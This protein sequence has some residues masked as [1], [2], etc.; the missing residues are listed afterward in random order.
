MYRIASN[1]SSANKPSPHLSHQQRGQV[2]RTMNN[3]AKE[4]HGTLRDFTT[5]DHVNH[6]ISCS[7]QY[8]WP[9]SRPWP[10]WVILYPDRANNGP[11]RPSLAALRNLDGP[12]LLVRALGSDVRTRSDMLGPLFFFVSRLGGR[13]RASISTFGVWLSL[14]GHRTP[15]DAT[16]ARCAQEKKREVEFK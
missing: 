15:F 14:A 7:L 16:S 1:I 4:I 2:A 5:A 10:N 13:A 3:P 12:L 8:E 9:S 6:R 11:Y